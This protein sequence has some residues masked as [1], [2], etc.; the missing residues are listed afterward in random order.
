[1][2]SFK[3][4]STPFNPSDYGFSQRRNFFLPITGHTALELMY[5]FCENE[6]NFISDALVIKKIRCHISRKIKIY[7][8]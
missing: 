2:R 7:I 4:H 1:M 3:I 8:A 5:F 6:R